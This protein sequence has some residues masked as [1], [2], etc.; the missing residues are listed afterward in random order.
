MSLTYFS[1]DIQDLLT[2]LFKHKVRYLIVGAEAVIYHGFARLSGDVVL[3]RSRSL[4]TRPLTRLEGI[5]RAQPAAFRKLNVR[6][7]SSS[8]KW[9]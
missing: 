6:G 9:R 1:Q 8:G 3:K 5:F 2:L 7:K 4:R